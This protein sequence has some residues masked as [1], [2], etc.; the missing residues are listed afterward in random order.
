M[1]DVHFITLLSE[2]QIYRFLS[3]F[4][5]GSLPRGL[6]DHA[7]HLAVGLVYVRRFGSDGALDLL[8]RRI[9]AYNMEAG[10][11]DDERNGYCDVITRQYLGEIARFIE[12]FPVEGLPEQLRGLIAASRREPRGVGISG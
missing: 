8:R 3:S 2:R 4:E 6:W 9:T 7:A 11:T 10:R 5:D 12:G 1:E